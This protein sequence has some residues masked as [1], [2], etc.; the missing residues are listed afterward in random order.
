MVADVADVRHRADE[1]EVLRQAGQPGVQLADPHPG[2][3]RGDRPVRPADLVGC[4]GLEVPGVDVAGPATEQDEDA[5]PLGGAT[6]EPAAGL[7]AGGNDAGHA[8]R[9]GANSPG[10]EEL[11]PGKP[12]HGLLSGAVWSW[13]RIDSPQDGRRGPGTG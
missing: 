10:L 2:D 4:A 7:D 11:A 13:H 1:G 8:D 3:L 12:R 5:R 9:E 6:G